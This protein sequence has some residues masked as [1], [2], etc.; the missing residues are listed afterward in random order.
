MKRLFY[1]L[2]TMLTLLSV[3]SA[4]EW[5]SIADICEQTPARWTQ[6]YETKWRTINID[7]EIRVPEVDTVPVILIEGAAEQPSLTAEET[8]W[9]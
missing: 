7:A 2:L 9:D 1:I 3:A 4:E 5:C 8:G 6:T